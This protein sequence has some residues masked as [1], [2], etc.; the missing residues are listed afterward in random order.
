[1]PLFLLG[2]P[3]ATPPRGTTVRVINPSRNVFESHF[4][5]FSRWRFCLNLT[6]TN[7][8]LLEVRISNLTHTPLP[9]SLPLLSFLFGIITTVFNVILYYRRKEQKRVIIVLNIG[10]QTVVPRR[11]DKKEKK[12]RDARATPIRVIRDLTVKNY[13]YIK[14]VNTRHRKVILARSAR[15]RFAFFFFFFK[16]LS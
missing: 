9:H 7:G 4:F 5:I 3:I 15:E 1:M 10:C 11:Y 8:I 14:N 6:N 16:S 2:T 12:K 13:S